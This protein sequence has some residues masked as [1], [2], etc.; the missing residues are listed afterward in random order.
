M[1]NKDG[2]EILYLAVTPNEYELPMAV[3]ETIADL[4]Q[5]FGVNKNTLKSSISHDK[6]GK[7]TGRKFIRVEMDRDEDV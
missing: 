5:K 4:A 2:V 1:I 3:E 7:T 6:S